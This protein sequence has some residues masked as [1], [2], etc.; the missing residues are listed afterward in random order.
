MLAGLKCGADLFRIRPTFG[1]FEVVTGFIEAVE[2]DA[3]VTAGARI[4]TVGAV[5]VL[6]RDGLVDLEHELG[7]TPLELLLRLGC[8]LLVAAHLKV[9]L[10]QFLGA[11]AVRG[12]AGGLDVVGDEVA[13]RVAL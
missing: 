8:P 2:H 4:V 11:D 7:G 5:E 12:H 9:G 1:S 6:G 13:D 10:E 3:E